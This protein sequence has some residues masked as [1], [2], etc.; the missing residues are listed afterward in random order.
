MPKTASNKIVAPA[1]KAIRIVR[2]ESLLILHAGSAF[3]FMPV[4][5]IMQA[6]NPNEG[7][8]EMSEAKGNQ[9]LN[10]RQ[11]TWQFVKFTLFSISAGIIQALSFTL[12]NEF[13]GFPYWP[14]YLIALVL[15]VVWNFTFNRRYT[16]RSIA[17]IP[18][19]MTLVF[20]Y[21]AVFTPLSTWWGD[22]L[23]NAGWNEYIVLGGT[24]VINFVT[25]FLFQSLVVFRKTIDTNAVAKRAKDKHTPE[26]GA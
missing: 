22:A 4:F 26:N 14:S 16:F 24:M 19:A 17:N 13:T 12:L 21:Y 11:R 5:A 20:L 7:A 15:S 8:E 10:A 1:V 3:T 2:Y 23:T 25:E 18:K 6:P 9:Q